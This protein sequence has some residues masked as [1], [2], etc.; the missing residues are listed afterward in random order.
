MFSEA[1]TK[2]INQDRLEGTISWKTCEADKT[3]TGAEKILSE[4]VQNEKRLRVMFFFYI[5]VY[6]AYTVIGI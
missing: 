2:L 4:L 5:L 6:R 3:S 1:E